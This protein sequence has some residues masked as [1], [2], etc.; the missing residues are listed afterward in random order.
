[1]YYCLHNLKTIV[2]RYRYRYICCFPPQRNS[3]LQNTRRVAYLSRYLILFNT[4]T[5]FRVNSFKIRVVAVKMAFNWC[6][7]PLK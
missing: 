4:K 3:V 2:D 5:P 7:R 6:N 1:M